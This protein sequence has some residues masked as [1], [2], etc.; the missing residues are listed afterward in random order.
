[1]FNQYWTSHLETD[2]E[3]NSFIKHLQ[4]SREIL[5]R[6]VQLIEDKERDL[7]SSERTMKAYENPNWAYLQAHKNGYASA[8]N[9]IKQL[10]SGPTE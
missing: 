10:I 6:L 7:G 3:K 4:G 8:M 9:I 1:M 5:D 2:E